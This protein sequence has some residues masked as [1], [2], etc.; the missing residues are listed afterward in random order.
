MVTNGEAMLKK[1]MFNFF[2]KEGSLADY[3][4]VKRWIYFKRMPAMFSAGSQIL[5]TYSYFKAC[6]YFTVSLSMKLLK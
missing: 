5:H 1:K 4:C 3:F 6:V 2:R